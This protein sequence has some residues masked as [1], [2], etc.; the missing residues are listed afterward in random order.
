MREEGGEG[1]HHLSVQ[2][3]GSPCG[4]FLIVCAY[5]EMWREEHR[6]GGNNEKKI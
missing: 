1:T 4:V 5:I 6:P 2:R 3:G